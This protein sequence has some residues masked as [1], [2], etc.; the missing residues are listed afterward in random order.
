MPALEAFAPQMVFISAGF[1]AHRE[2][3]LGQ[4]GL[5]EADYEWI[6][7]RLVDVAD[8]HAQGRI[9]SCLEGGYALSGTGAQRGRPRARA[10]RPEP[11]MTA[12]F[13]CSPPWPRSSFGTAAELDARRWSG[14]TLF[15]AQRADGEAVGELLVFAGCL[16]LA[17]AGGAAA[18]RPKSRPAARSGS[19]TASSTACCSR[20]WRC[21]WRCWRA[22]LQGWL[23]PAVFKLVVPVLVS[24]AVIRLTV[25][26]LHAA[27]PSRS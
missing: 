19:A 18:A 25:R 13:A 10:G 21:C 17:W 26:V 4:L 11:G 3:D 6:T 15:S 24:L 22:G 8:R 2:D 9:V 5:V 1:D 20:C 23:P 27:F 16:L 14:R 7:R 12:R